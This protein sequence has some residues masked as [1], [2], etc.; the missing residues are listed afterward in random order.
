MSVKKPIDWSKYNNSK[1]NGAPLGGNCPERSKEIDRRLVILVKKFDGDPMSLGQIAKA[2]GVSKAAIQQIEMKA[3][4]RLRFYAKEL[5]S[6]LD[7][8]FDGSR[9][10]SDGY[11]EEYPVHTNIGS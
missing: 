1:R 4:K 5:L 6:E 10:V 8:S 3:M 9:Y 7:H 2:C 11:R